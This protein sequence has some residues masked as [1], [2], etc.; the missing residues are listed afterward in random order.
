MSRK[1]RHANTFVPR[2]RNRRESIDGTPSSEYLTGNSA[3]NEFIPVCAH[4]REKGYN[5]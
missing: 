5:I 2:K 1:A 4:S 3:I